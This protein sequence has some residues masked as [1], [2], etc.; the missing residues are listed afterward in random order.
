MSNQFDDP[1]NFNPGDQL[2]GQ[3]INRN[4]LESRRLQ[5]RML[6]LGTV[7][8]TGSSY[9]NNWWVVHPYTRNIDR[10]RLH[11][12]VDVLKDTKVTG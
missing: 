12:S 9:A 6:T 2:H 8:I 3:G 1:M 7:S 5:G 11:T 4:L 10:T